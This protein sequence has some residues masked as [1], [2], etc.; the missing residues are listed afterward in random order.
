MVSRFAVGT[1][2]MTLALASSGAWMS[3]ARATPIGGIAS[4]GR[5]ATVNSPIE[6][7]GYYR[8]Y[9]RPHFGFYSPFFSFSVG[10]RYGYYGPRYYGYS[11]YYY[12]GPYY[13]PRYYRY[14]H[15]HWRHRYW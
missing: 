11:P 14:H 6:A 12:G 10:P 9:R 5:E 4:V 8:R 3:D 15:R 13:G 2:F 1:L 7:A